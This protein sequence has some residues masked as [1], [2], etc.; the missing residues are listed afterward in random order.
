MVQKKLKKNSI[1]FDKHHTRLLSFIIVFHCSTV[2]IGK[3][4]KYSKKYIFF[5]NSHRKV[6]GK[7]SQRF[8]SFG[9]VTGKKSQ[10][11]YSFGIVTLLTRQPLDFH[12]KLTDGLVVNARY[13]NG[14]QLNYFFVYSKKTI[15]SWVFKCC[16]QQKPIIRR[17]DSKTYKNHLNF[18]M[19]E[20]VI[21]QKPVH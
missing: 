17:K 7:K 20:A 6:F 2:I 16:F 12:S 1:C 18:F 11:S 13:P 15:L 19:T 3:N 21:I 14:I 9:I 4:T 8:Y 10:R 5:R